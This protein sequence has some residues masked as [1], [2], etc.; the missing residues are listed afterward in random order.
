MERVCKACDLA[1][2][3]EA[4]W[5][6]PMREIPPMP[7][8]HR[9]ARIVDEVER[10]QTVTIRALSESLGVSR[11]TLRKDISLLDEAG[12]LRQVR[13]GAMIRD[14]EE[15]PV[16]ERVLTNPDGKGAIAAAAAALVPD[17]ATIL[18]DSG[19]TTRLLA[20]RLVERVATGMQ[21][22]VFTNDLKIALM[23]HPHGIAVHVLGG[24]LAEGEESTGGLDAIDMLRGYSVDLAFVGVGG[25]GAR[26]AVSDYSREGV[27]LRTAML[28][29]AR[30]PVLL[31]DH[32]KIDRPAPVRLAPLPENLRLITD[33]PLPSPLADALSRAVVRVI[34]A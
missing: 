33:R 32:T 16:E 8:E 23:L 17:G 9:R 28:A 1:K 26:L 2:A 13:G 14:H 5:K 22:S 4:R 34:L 21:L 31:A 24:R 19:S 10:H 29:A 25:L 3:L 30:T 20:E 7:A 12:R 27:A 15:P 11:E 6:P 18:L